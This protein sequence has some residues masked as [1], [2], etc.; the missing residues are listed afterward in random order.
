MS[1][2]ENLQ[3][4]F[5]DQMKLMFDD[6][7]NKA[8]KCNE[9]SEKSS[10]VHLSFGDLNIPVRVDDLPLLYIGSRLLPNVVNY[11][12]N[13]LPQFI[14]P[15]IVAYLQELSSLRDDPVTIN[16][17]YEYLKNVE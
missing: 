2:N 13:I 14:Y 11:L 6:L 1:V 8:S 16:E 3:D 4:G 10:N 15:Y 5:N 17:I 7:L 12:V 9:K